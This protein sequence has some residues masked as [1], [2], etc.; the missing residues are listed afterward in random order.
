[1]KAN[2]D[3]C[4]TFLSR[5]DGSSLGQRCEA[6]LSIGML[7]ARLSARFPAADAESWDR[8]GL[9]VG[10]PCVPLARAAIALDPTLK[11][12]R[13][14]REAGCNLLL[15][16]HPAFLEPPFAIVADPRISYTGSIAYQAVASG[17]ALANFHTS[18]D[19][20]IEARCALPSMLGLSVDAVLEPIS[21][22]GCG[23]ADGVALPQK[24]YGHICAVSAA[25]PMTLGTL[26]ARC[27]SVFGRPPRIWGDIDAPIRTICTWTGSAGGAG[28][29][30]LE[31]GVDV[32]ICG[33]LK[34]HEALEL[35]DLGLSV[36]ELGHDVSELPLTAILAQAV[37]DCG[38][39]SEDICIL[40]QNDN[41][42][43][44]ESR[45]V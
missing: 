23:E 4:T 39:R 18:L 34:Y 14:A 7:C 44:P 26:G 17:V 43:T 36:I 35:R 40:K 9:S 37:L 20:S 28:R 2:P 27:L 1:M 21:N 6:P 8:T 25:D 41:W 5:V 13:E 10:D 19:V 15:T 3:S 42:Q 22:R 29:R 45:R 38:M 30:C 12:I 32:L 33:E 16:H 24:G 31:A 11:A